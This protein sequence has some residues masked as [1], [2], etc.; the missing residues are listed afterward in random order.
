[1]LSQLIDAPGAA[2]DWRLYYLR[3]TA[4]EEV[5]DAGEDRG[6]PE[7]ALKLNP[8]EPE[9]LNFLGYFWIDRGE[10]LKEALAMIERAVDAKPQS[11][12]IIDSLGWAY[13]RLGDYKDAVEKLEAAVDARSRHPGGQRPPRRRLLAG[14]PQDRGARSSGAGCCRSSR[15]TS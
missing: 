9:L 4:Y 10:H 13:Y 8:D 12:E 3:A 7:A 14:G 2:P 11:G 6:R 5:G 15:T 1:M